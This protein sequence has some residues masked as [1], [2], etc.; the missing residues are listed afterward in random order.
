M[1]MKIEDVIHYGNGKYFFCVWMQYE[2][3][4]IFST[5]LKNIE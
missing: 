5:K 4:L 1:F 3:K 2:R